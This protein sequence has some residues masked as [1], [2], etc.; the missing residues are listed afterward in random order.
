MSVV[1]A[2]LRVHHPCPYCDLSVEFPE[3]KFLLWCDNRRDIFLISGPD[4]RTV[5]RVLRVAKQAFHATPLAIDRSEALVVVPDFEWDD[6][7]SVTG[8]A[9]RS[10]VWVL[11]PVEYFEGRETYRLLAPNRTTLEKL[12]TRLRRLGEV[13]LL[14]VS[15]RSSLHALRD[16]PLASV[17]VFDGLTDRQA[18][19]LLSAYEAGLF[20]VPARA[21]W[22]EVARRAGLSRSTFG[23]HLRKAQ[24]HLLANSYSSLR[25]H[26]EPA[27][28]PVLLPA[29]PSRRRSKRATIKTR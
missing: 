5:H 20:D 22:D 21:R 4:P 19:S 18:R 16:V 29:L 24:L 8:L 13:E 23:E 15:D 14:S 27:D 26:L 3:V 1:D 12:V 9:R 17:H 2:R 7:P 10:G 6:P 25:T 28:P 11:H